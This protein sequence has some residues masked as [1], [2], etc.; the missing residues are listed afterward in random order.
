M[1]YFKVRLKHNVKKLIIIFLIATVFSFLVIFIRSS[2]IKED[3]YKIAVIDEDKSDLSKLFVKNLIK[4]DKLYVVE[5]DELSKAKTDLELRNV[6]F[7]VVIL[8]DFKKNIKKDL[9][10]DTI[11]VFYRENDVTTDLLKD[12]V[13]TEVV[14]MWTYDTFEQLGKKNKVDYNVVDTSKYLDFVVK[15][16]YGDDESYVI[17]SDA[18]ILFWIL[19]ILL[20][21]FFID[22]SKQQFVEKNIGIVMRLKTF[23]IGNVYYGEKIFFKLLVIFEIVIS[24]VMCYIIISGKINA[25]ILWLFVVFILVGILYFITFEIL[26]LILSYFIKMTSKYYLTLQLMVLVWVLLALLPMKMVITYLSPIKL[27]G[28]FVKK[29]A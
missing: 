18:Y 9:Y 10:E 26:S 1:N 22:L 24:I 3:A 4:N 6:D 12:T 5:R 19:I 20:S 15:G 25:Y 8:K 11:D 29:F 17:K 2:L 23:G 14:R 16:S 13:S 27:L 28:M 21:I 7:V